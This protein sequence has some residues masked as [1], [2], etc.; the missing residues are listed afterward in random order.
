MK[1]PLTDSNA[2]FRP[3]DDGMTDFVPAQFAREMER[4]LVEARMSA[5]T[6]RRHHANAE[7]VIQKL[8]DALSWAIDHCQPTIEQ[9][10]MSD[11][12]QRFRDALALLSNSGLTPGDI[13]PD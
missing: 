12:P 6:L 7:Q 3:N 5:D 13:T 9:R 4:E 10:Y 8:R 11:Y 1:T 2:T